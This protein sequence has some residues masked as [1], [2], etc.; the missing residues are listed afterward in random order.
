MGVTSNNVQVN[1]KV[2][3]LQLKDIKRTTLVSWKFILIHYTLKASPLNSI[4]ISFP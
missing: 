2:T 4:Q 1:Y 3:D